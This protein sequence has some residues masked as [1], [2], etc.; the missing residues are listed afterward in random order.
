VYVEFLPIQGAELEGLHEILVTDLQNYGMPFIRYR[1]NDCALVATG[2]CAC[3][4]GFPL[5]KKIVGRTT[6]NFYM[7]N[8]DV[9]PGVALT[10]RVIQVCSGLRKLQVIQKTLYDFHVRYVPGPNFGT[11]DLEFLLTRLRVFFPDS[12]RWTFEEVT[13]IERERSGKTRFCISYV[14]R[15]LT[16]AAVAEIST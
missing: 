1:I 12:I 6:D 14:R 15:D 16:S 8:G 13:E 5:I 10:N 9:V 3:G 2:P 7:P 4:R 11:S